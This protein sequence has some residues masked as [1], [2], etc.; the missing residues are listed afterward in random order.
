[1]V[2]SRAIWL[3][4]GIVVLSIGCQRESERMNR[5]G[6][7]QCTGADMWRK[8]MLLE[9]ERSLSYA[10][11]VEMI[12]S[13]A[14]GSSPQQ[15]ED[16][17]S[18]IDKGIDVLIVSPNEKEPLTPIISEAYQAGI[19]V[20]VLDRRTSNSLYTSYIG[21]DNYDLGRTVADFILQE[22]DSARIVELW[23][24][25]SSSPAQSRH[26]GFRNHLLTEGGACRVVDE[27]YGNWTKESVKADLRMILEERG[28][29]IDVIF[30]HNDFMALGAV[31]LCEELG[32]DKIEVLGIDGLS[33]PSGGM[34]LVENGSM[35]ATFLYPTGGKEAIQAALDLLAGREVP[36]E[37]I[38]STTAITASNVGVL[39]SQARKINSQQREIEAQQALISQRDV[40]V[41]KQRIALI[42]LLVLVVATIALGTFSLHQ[43]R[44]IRRISHRLSVQNRTLAEQH[45]QLSKMAADSESLS[46]RRLAFFGNISNEFRTPLTL[47][48]GPIDALLSDDRMP[49]GMRVTVSTIRQ[50]ALR[51]LRLVNQLQDIKKLESREFGLKAAHGDMVAFLKGIKEEFDSLAEESEVLFTLHESF[52]SIP[53]W[54][55]HQILDKVVFNMLSN[56]FKYTPA[57]GMVM[58]RVGMSEDGRNAQVVISDTGKGMSEDQ[59]ESILAS[60]SSTRLTNTLQSSLGL[61]LSRELIALHKG[62]LEIESERDKGTT[63]R[64]FLPL[65]DTYLSD[66]QRLGQSQ[67]ERGYDVHGLF[68]QQSFEPLGSARQFALPSSEVDTV[69]LVDGDKEVTR[70][71]ERELSQM[72]KVRSFHGRQELMAE[73]RVQ[74]PSAI[75]LDQVLLDAAGSEVLSELQRDVAYRTIPVVVTSALNSSSEKERAIRAGAELHLDKP[76]NLNLLTA[77]LDRLI[78]GR[79]FLK[80]FY[81]SSLPSGETELTSDR[82][83]ARMVEGVMQRSLSQGV[84]SSVKQLSDEL[85]MSRSKLYRQMQSNFG[86]KATEYIMKWRM[87]RA[88]MLLRESRNRTVAEI[89]L[90]LGFS[91]SSHFSMAFK[92]YMGVTPTEY[93]VNKRES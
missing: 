41:G 10:K 83:F 46:E 29:E 20:L 28:S 68:V 79:I 21:A 80:S 82:E 11:G 90:E 24:L 81:Q 73:L 44:R 72:Y 25:Q 77:H 31:E 53:M 88:A 22:R 34:E 30:A 91:S 42:V 47:I 63:F 51:L 89:A 62:R 1:M 56:A 49:A 12:Y 27:V 36:R 18:M 70:F 74:S 17:R 61:V 9:M 78:A 86:M 14:L 7:S 32:L 64:I 4:A 52:T 6:F 15:I 33:S 26:D 60:G 43:L 57:G 66:D 40:S 13:D 59:L 58:L 50:N 2:R 75:V 39:R 45:Q 76:F 67:I 84:V 19:P 85:G 23:G 71:L 8:G 54:F 93:R 35:K 37:I 5:I 16:I 92:K 69:F 3:I 55:D 38:L 48:L 65:S 87:N